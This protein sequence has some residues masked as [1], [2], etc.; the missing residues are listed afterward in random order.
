M[1]MSRAM[2]HSLLRNQQKKGVGQTLKG[3]KARRFDSWE[4]TGGCPDGGGTRM[5]YPLCS[6]RH[7]DA[8]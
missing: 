5:N 8:R 3:E 1:M 4:G 7:D 2:T 6:P